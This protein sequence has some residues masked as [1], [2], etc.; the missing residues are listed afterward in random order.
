MLQVIDMSIQA[1]EKKIEELD[2]AQ[3]NIEEMTESFFPP[4]KTMSYP[5]KKISPEVQNK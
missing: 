3:S 4:L 1:L 5:H 2:K